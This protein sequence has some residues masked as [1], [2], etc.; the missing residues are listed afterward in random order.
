MRTEHIVQTILAT[1]LI[2]GLVIM[3]KDIRDTQ[4]TLDDVQAELDK[5]S[6]HIAALP[7]F[8]LDLGTSDTGTAT[9]VATQSLQHAIEQAL[10]KTLSRQVYARADA[11]HTPAQ[12]E[13][14]HIDQATL[15][16]YAQASNY[17]DAAL[18]AGYWG[19]EQKARFDALSGTL[20]GGQL[21]ELNSRL[22]RAVN[23]GEL[24]VDPAAFLPGG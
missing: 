7:A 19:A 15:D 20:S 4:A 6:V 21:H 24:D 18:S 23:A 3:H 9:G 17:L 8:E 12:S 16:Q 13:E 10:E 14:S 1:G 2:L 5:V 11:E 22:A